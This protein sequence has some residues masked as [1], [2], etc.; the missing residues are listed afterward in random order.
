[1]EF[2]DIAFVFEAITA[3][4]MKIYPYCQRR[5]CS[6][7]NALQRKSAVS[8][9]ISLGVHPL[10]G[11]K[12]VRGGENTLFSSKMR[13]YHSP[14]GANGCCVTSNKSLTCLR[15]VFTL[16]WTNYRH[17]FASRGFISVSWAFLLVHVKLLQRIVSYRLY[18]NQ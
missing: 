11:V 10:W 18:M 15:L 5:N 7:L 2:R 16:N 13:Q 14:D 6:P 12:Q 9:L 17:A 1:L 4:R 3:K 8:A